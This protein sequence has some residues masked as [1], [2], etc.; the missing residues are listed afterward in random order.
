[1]ARARKS[2][3]AGKENIRLLPSGLKPARA[4]TGHNPYVIYVD[5]KQPGAQHP[6]ILIQNFHA[7]YAAKYFLDLL[8]GD[9]EYHT[10]DSIGSREAIRT[11]FGLRISMFGDDL[12]MLLNYKP[13]ELER[14]WEDHQLGNYVSNLKYGR[15]SEDREEEVVIGE[16]GI[17]TKKIKKEK[18]EKPVKV[19]ID[20]S[21]MVSANEI[22]KELGETGLDVRT[23][24]RKMMPKPQGGWLFPKAEAKDVAEKIK[25]ALKEAR[26]KKAKK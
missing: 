16:D 6:R 21:G 9:N 12:H 20:K 15:N 7:E 1:M 3:K 23:V 17:Q 8:I 22:A 18:K 25:K 26:K 11:S 2:H 10:V 19:K 14:E 13:D 24:L 4:Q 5:Y